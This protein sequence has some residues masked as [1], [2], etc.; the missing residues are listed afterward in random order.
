MDAV[1]SVK[2]DSKIKEEFIRLFSDPHMPIYFKQKLVIENYMI[3][4]ING[5]NRLKN[6]E[7]TFLDFMY[8]DKGERLNYEIRICDKGIFE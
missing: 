5:I 2:V 7:S 1:Y 6:N 4:F 8:N 3:C